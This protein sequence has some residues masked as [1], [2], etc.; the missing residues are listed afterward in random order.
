DGIRDKLVTGVQTCALPIF[1]GQ[2]RHYGSGMHLLLQVQLDYS[3]GTSEIVVTDSTWKGS[4][5]PIV[6]SDLLMGETYDARRV[7]VGWDE[8]GFDDAQWKSVTVQDRGD[9]PLVAD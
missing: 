5:G 2:C 4:I 3:D 8:P 7:L 9:V 6:F 1:G